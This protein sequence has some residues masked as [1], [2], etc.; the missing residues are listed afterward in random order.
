MGSLTTMA[1]KRSVSANKGK[2]S[3]NRATVLTIRGTQEWRDWLERAANHCRLTTSTL[4]DL[5]VTRF[6]REQG[7]EEAPPKR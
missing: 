1:K 3:P 4:V 5:A 6:A 7:F 2:A